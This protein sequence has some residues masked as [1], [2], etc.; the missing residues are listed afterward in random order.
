M[1]TF[2]YVLPINKT[3]SQ[4]VESSPLDITYTNYCTTGDSLF[5]LIN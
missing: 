3:S 5:G 2:N 1:C 4:A